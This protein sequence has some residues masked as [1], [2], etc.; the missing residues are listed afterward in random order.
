MG[1][2]LEYKKLIESRNNIIDDILENITNWNGDI[3]SGIELVDN[4]R[5]EIGKIKNINEKI[6][7]INMSNIHD[8]E[9][10]EKLN[11]LYIEQKRL[12]KVLEIKQ[13]E[14]ISERQ[15]LNKKNKVAESYIYKKN[16]PIFIDKDIT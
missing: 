4:N 1:T 11:A 9:Y 12:F 6:D 14:L 8:E 15:Q 3:E 10:K 16:K 7:A 5:V 2:N 13:R